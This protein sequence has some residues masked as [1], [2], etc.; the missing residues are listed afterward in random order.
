[1][2]FELTPTEPTTPEKI[3]LLRQRGE[4]KRPE[5]NRERVVIPPGKIEPGTGGP[6]GSLFAEM[7]PQESIFNRLSHS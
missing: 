7:E 4:L 6:Q 1:M 5:R 3:E 2:T